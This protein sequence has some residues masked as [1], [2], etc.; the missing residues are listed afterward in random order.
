MRAAWKDLR[1]NPLRSSLTALS[2]FVG[3]LSIVVIVAGGAVARDYL[4][5]VAEQRDGRAP[6]EAIS[7]G[8]EPTTDPS[9]VARFIDHLPQSSARAVSARV[10]LASP[11]DVAPIPSPGQPVSRSGVQ[12]VLVAGD[13]P[14]VRRLS[15]VSGRWLSADD[16]TAPFEVVVNEEAARVL[17]VEGSGVS[18]SGA[19]DGVASTGLVVGVVNDGEDS[20][21]NAYVKAA[22]LLARASTGQRHGSPAPLALTR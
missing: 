10:D 21:A 11:L 18:L 19:R 22:P 8:V 13:L 15:L 1:L 6:T 20:Q 7:V 16:V 2:L 3:I 17:G 14:G 9:G 12:A 5:A 4:L